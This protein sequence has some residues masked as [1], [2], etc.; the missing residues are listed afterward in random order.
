MSTKAPNSLVHINES[1]IDNT[2]DYLYEY[3]RKEERFHML[4]SGKNAESCIIAD[5]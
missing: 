4:K 2:E 1:G 3:C 5:K